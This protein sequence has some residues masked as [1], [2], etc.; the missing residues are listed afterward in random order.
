M[1]NRCV[2]TAEE[3]NV[4]DLLDFRKETTKT[5]PF[6]VPYAQITKKLIRRIVNECKGR[7]D[8]ICV[9]SDACVTV[10]GRI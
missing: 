5:W 10:L 6:K 4:F 9:T 8:D 1:V 3:K 7:S 2:L